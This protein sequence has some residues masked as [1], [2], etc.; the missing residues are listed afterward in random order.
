MIVLR[1]KDSMIISTLYGTQ[2]MMYGMQGKYDSSMVYFKNAIA[3]AESMHY[4][5]NLGRYYGGLAIGYQMQSNYPEALR[6][7]QKSLQLAEDQNNISS[8]AYTLLNMGNTYQ[9]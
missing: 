6:Y 2:G 7:Q 8:Q 5:Q 1:L 3:I 9:K 4:T